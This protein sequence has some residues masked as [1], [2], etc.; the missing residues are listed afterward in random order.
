MV[1][2][3]ILRREFFQLLHS[4][5]GLGPLFLAMAGAGAMFIY[6]LRGAEGTAESLPA[7]WGLAVALALPFL[8]AV[9]ASRG[10]TL[11]REHGMMRLMFSSPVRARL[12]V[13]GKVYAAWLVCLLYV[14]GMGVVCWAFLRWQLPMGAQIP[15]SW[16]GFVTGGV[17]LAVQALLWCS[18][19]TLVSLFSRSSASTFL[20]SLMACLLAPPLVYKGMSYL[21]PY[22]TVQWPWLPL[23]SIVYDCA[24]GLI[25]VRVLLT[26]LIVSQVLVYVAGMVF[27]ALRLCATER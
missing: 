1:F 24:G 9:S 20:M 5:H 11:D 18:I 23:Q 19:A 12:W 4:M 25:D 7:L 26:C 13:F 22:S 8:A 21:A 14:G 6:F 15:F 3:T 17:A 16:F 27:D 2:L 10:F